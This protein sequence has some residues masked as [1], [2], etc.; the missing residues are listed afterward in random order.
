MIKCTSKE[1]RNQ[2]CL[3]NILT[4]AAR[5]SQQNDKLLENLTDGSDGGGG[6]GGGGGGDDITV[7][8][9]AVVFFFVNITVVKCK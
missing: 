7:R 2:G 5:T 3:P 9:Y 6:G 4:N 1:T 8:L